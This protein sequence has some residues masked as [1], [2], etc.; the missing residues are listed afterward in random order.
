MLLIS[1]TM[2][3]LIIARDTFIFLMIDFSI[4]V[5]KSEKISTVGNPETTILGPGNRLS[6]C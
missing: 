5:N 2:E 1:Q 3:G 4:G 6:Q